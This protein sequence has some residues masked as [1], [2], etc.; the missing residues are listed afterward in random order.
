MRKSYLF[1]LLLVIAGCTASVEKE[2]SYE[3][4]F[5]YGHEV[6]EFRVLSQI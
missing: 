6:S 4:H 1:C 2:H 5:T 3:G